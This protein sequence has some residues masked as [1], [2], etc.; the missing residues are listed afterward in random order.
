MSPAWNHPGK[1]P[2]RI[3]KS[4]NSLS[5]RIPKEMVPPDLSQDAEIEYKDGAW[6]IR[7]VQ[8]R[9][10]TDLAAKFRNFSPGFMAE[11]RQQAE[12]ELERDWPHSPAEVS[13]QRKRKA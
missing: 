5:V 12:L 13:G 11:G 8:R 10:L 7:P 3:Y 2:T 9:K 1:L 6:T 4:G